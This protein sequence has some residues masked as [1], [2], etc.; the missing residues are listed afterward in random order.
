MRVLSSWSPPTCVSSPPSVSCARWFPPPRSRPIRVTRPPIPTSSGADISARDKAVAD[1]AFEGRGPGTKNGEAAA[2]W[3]A[4]ELKRVGREARQSRQLFPERARGRDH[5]RRRRNR[6]FTF[7]TPQGAMTP[8]FPDE[9][10][11]WTPQY[12]S[13]RGE[14]DEVAAGVRRLWRRR[15]G[16]RWNDYAGVD[17][18][19][20]T[21]VILINDP[22][23]EDANPDPEL[24]QGQGDDLLRPLD[25]QVR[26]GR[27]PGRGRRHHRARDRSRPLM[28]GR[29]CAIRT[30]ARSLWL[31]NDGQE[32]QAWC[33]SRAG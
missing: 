7:D 14:G 19:G 2:Q 20:K 31:D 18:K 28:A 23:N 17:V 32:Q 10:I 30:R 24:L 13:R 12:A 33:R 25:L 22:G 9:A 29:S 8:K 6:S 15:A 26:R 27:A 16:I 3:I 1:D 4:D 5:A 21:V 11:Y